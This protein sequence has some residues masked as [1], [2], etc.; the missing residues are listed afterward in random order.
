MDNG[1]SL[2]KYVEDTTV[3]ARGDNILSANS[4][5][6]SQGTLDISLGGTSMA[7]PFVTGSL[8]PMVQRAFHYM[9]AKQLGDVLLSTANDNIT[10]QSGLVVYPHGKRPEEA[11]SIRRIFS[12]IGPGA[13]WT[14]QNRNREPA[15]VFESKKFGMD[16]ERLYPYGEVHVY[17]DA[18]TQELVGQGVVDAG[19]A[20]ARGPGA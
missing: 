11:Q 6:A 20:N 18:M 2:A 1:S 13:E 8:C 17:Y 5:Y 14:W 15:L 3:A 4:A 19:G 12:L 7:A 10:V 16:L 9:S